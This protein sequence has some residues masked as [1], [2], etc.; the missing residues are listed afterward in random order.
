MKSTTREKANLKGHLLP[1]AFAVAATFV[2]TLLRMGLGPLVGGGAPF[3]TYFVAVVIVVWYVGF[4][5][6]L[7]S[8]LLSV[9]AATYFFISPATTSPFILSKSADRVTVLGFVVASLGVTLLLDLQRKAL[10]TVEHE[11]MRRRIAEE[12]EREQRQWFETTLGSIGD[13]VVATDTQGRVKFMN[14]LAIELTGWRLEEAKG[15]PL[16]SVF[17][18]VDE[19]A[20]VELDSPTE[21][22]IRDGV[23]TGLANHT[24]LIS[25]DGRKTPI[26]DCAAP[27]KRD[28]STLGAVLVFR[29]VAARRE[30]QRQIENSE[31][32]YR[33]LFQSNPQP[34]W[35]FDRD[36]LAFLAV[37]N[38]AVQKYGYTTE[39]FLGMTIADIRP[40]E[41]VPA[42]LQ[43]VGKRTPGLH[44][45][46]P[47]RHRTRDG[48]IISVEIAA[49]PIVFE[50]QNAS[51]VMAA[52]VTERQKLEEQF[53][54]A[55]RLESI[56]RL[57][58]GIAHDFNNLLTVI[59][60]Y[61]SVILSELPGGSPLAQRVAEIQGAG[62][63]AAALTQQLLA[64][65]RRQI[66]QPKVL[67]VNSVIADVDKMLRR[68][69]GEDI[70]L[71]V[72]LSP[73]L[74]NIKVDDGQL[75]Q[76]I[77]NLAVNARDAMPQG[78]SLIIE[79]SNVYLD[80]SYA[81]KH[82]EVHAGAYIMLAVTDSGTGMT[83]EVQERIFEPFFTTK[84]P[85]SGTGLGLATV[86][87]MVRQAGGWIW[88][89][90]EPRSGTT[91][92]IYFPR[93]EEAVPGRHTDA[94]TSSPRGNETILVVEDQED[95]RKLTVA[96]LEHY[97]YRVLSAAGGDE[98]IALANSFM[99]VID[100]LITDVIMPGM[101]GRELAERLVADRKLRVLFMS[102]YTENAIAH[103]GILDS[104]LAYIQ[105][106]FTPESLAQKVREILEPESGNQT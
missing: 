106:P 41:D 69:I 26:D 58:G 72:K 48:T 56:G 54:Q 83:P 100:L 10:K 61:A 39:E 47:W 95:V 44:R 24:L 103:R 70:D 1:Y 59:N 36:T 13:A 65:S 46:G 11:A 5:A 9:A 37:N 84:P 53:R 98:A 7:L 30:A 81:A 45:D 12:T 97:G 3:L 64:F 102:G 33:L 28:G 96:V 74:D 57:A 88:V 66:V 6:A 93:T 8:V 49:H 18:I 52:D 105:K 38:A 35:V 90:S 87:G 101:S 17:H 79:T 55:Q 14:R 51:L 67:N 50:G 32:R 68:L 71:V 22:V 78:G 62:Q 92:K 77:M 94:A 23:Q 15:M 104:G 89:Y 2:A 73:D 21:K 85:G 19:Q 60:G 42:L 91:F 25:K 27:I 40:A 20:G 75:Q 76:V 31:R 99:G 16:R 43:D 82:P 86:H 80:E 34:M 29:D 63:R 4:R